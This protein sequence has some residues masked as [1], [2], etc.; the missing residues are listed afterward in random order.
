[1]YKHFSKD[2][3]SGADPESKT[4]RREN[5]SQGLSLQG[6]SPI[7]MQG[8]ALHHEWIRD[9]STPRASRATQDSGLPSS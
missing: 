1:M 3:G 6:A 8:D 2:V 7:R 9:S 4:P 5:F